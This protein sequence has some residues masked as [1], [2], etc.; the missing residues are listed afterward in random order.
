[1]PALMPFS[2]NGDFRCFFQNDFQSQK[3]GCLWVM[4]VGD[5]GLSRGA[6]GRASAGREDV[7]RQMTNF[8]LSVK[9]G[10][11]APG[12][13]GLLFLPVLC[14]FLRVLRVKNQPRNI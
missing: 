14:L 8:R 13:L 10:L 9:V 12:A 7:C 2:H 6:Q 4:T 1:M 5:T 11:S 3:Q